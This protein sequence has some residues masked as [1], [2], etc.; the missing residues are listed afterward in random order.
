MRTWDKMRSVLTDREKRG[1]VFLSFG[2]LI[3]SVSEAFGIGIIIPILNLATDPQKASLSWMAGLF[4]SLTGI[5]DPKVYLSALIIAAVI[6]F[7]AKSAYSLYILYKQQA[8]TYNVQNRLAGDL[9]RLYL[10]K[11]YSF[12]LESNSA[13]LFKNISVES[14]QF[15]NGLLNSILVISSEAMV[16]ASIFLLLVYV[17]PVVTLSLIAVFL[18]IVG[19][20]NL[21]FRKKISGYSKDREVYSGEVYKLGMESL[22]AVKEIKVYNVPGFF[23]ERFFRSGKK[24]VESFI[25]FYTLSNLPRYILETLLFCGALLLLLVNVNSRNNF[26]ELVPMMVV[27]GVAGLRLLPSVN[28]IYSNINAAHFSLNSLDIIY[29]IFKEEKAASAKGAPAADNDLRHIP[30]ESILLK[31]VTF[32]YKGALKPIFAGLNLAIPL[33]RT[34]V[35]VGAT[36]AG[37]STLVDILMGLLIP[38]EGEL[39]YKEEQVFG[40]GIDR[41]RSRVG[42]VPQ[43]ILLLDDTLEAN[44]AFGVPPEQIDRSRLE[45]AINISQLETFVRELPL[46]VKNVVGERGVRISGGQRQRIGIARAL[47]RSP[48]I[49]ILDEATSSLDSHTESE[50]NK[51]IKELSGRLTVIIIAHRVSTIEQA[52][53]I[54]VMESGRIVGQGSYAELMQNSEVFRKITNQQA[55]EEREGQRR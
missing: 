35:F 11:P 48:E 43:Q 24:Y 40:E 50:V 1:L 22:H 8:F 12:F 16:I 52:D 17:Y 30:Q 4:R 37:K 5:A 7:I 41:Y 38:G 23:V 42:Y 45:E 18:S 9:L 13:L 27:M 29:A 28:K 44:I 33:N 47:Y 6:L 32:T 49:L 53:I 3:L 26:L 21:V 31:D 10:D 34:A 2:M 46:G 39:F 14:S 20:M 15:A 19:V 36:G 55:Q 54:Y 25:K 51:A